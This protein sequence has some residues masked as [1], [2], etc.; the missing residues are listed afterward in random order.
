MA[1]TEKNQI[2][3][4]YLIETNIQETGANSSIAYLDGIPVFGTFSTN[5]D[6]LNSVEKMFEKIDNKINNTKQ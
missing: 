2:Y 4:G 1:T 3:N 5:L 6:K